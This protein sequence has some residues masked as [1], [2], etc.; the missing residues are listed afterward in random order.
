MDVRKSRVVPSKHA[1]R[2][3]LDGRVTVI[4]KTLSVSVFN[5]VLVLYIVL[6]DF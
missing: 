1:C 5:G 4:V 3:Q 6:T 2:E